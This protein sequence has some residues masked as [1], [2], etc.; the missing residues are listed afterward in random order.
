M[1]GMPKRSGQS[2][3]S[4]IPARALL[5]TPSQGLGGGIERYVQTLE[6]AFV[7]QGVWYRRLDLCGSGVAS[8]LRLLAEAERLWQADAGYTRIVVAHRTLLPVAWLLSRRHKVGG[9]SVVC[10]GT[11]VW[12]A[13]F[14]PRWIIEK[15]LMRWPTV[16]VVAVSSFTSGALSGNLHATVLPPGLSGAWFDTL[17]KASTT[18]NARESGIRLV[19]AFRL[20]DWRDKGL[21]ELLGAVAGLNRSDVHLTI[22]GTGEPT[23]ELLR[24]VRSSQHCALVSGLR[25]H[26]LAYLLASADVFILATRTRTGAQPSGEGFGLVLL[27]AQVAGTPVVAPAYGGS[28]D[29]YIN[30]VTGRAPMDESAAALG[31]L[32]ERMLGEPEELTRMSKHA[33]EWSRECF[34]PEK[35]SVMAVSKVL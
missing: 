10:H 17:V 6:W 14:R 15:Y 21:P 12:G 7:K 34:D 30:G 19:T 26:E 8:H 13:R 33:A 31:A 2:V 5:L 1:R 35:Y 3:C 29:A 23:Q 25:D 18:T 9:I 20:S 16:R 11:D 4:E 27:E 32:L 28:H 22:C 24:V